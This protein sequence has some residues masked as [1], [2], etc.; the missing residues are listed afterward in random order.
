MGAYMESLHR[1]RTL[2]ISRI[3]PGH[4]PPLDGGAAVLDRYIEH[5]LQREAAIV[6]ALAPGP[7]TLEEV[8]A[9]AYADTPEHLHPIA[10]HS[11]RAHL[12]LLEATGRASRL[13]DHW[14]LRGV[15]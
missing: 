11:A 8:V 14:A 5:R 6:E 4:W 2:R 10:A 12:Q 1:L 15:D 9:R 13:N 7:A 3:Y